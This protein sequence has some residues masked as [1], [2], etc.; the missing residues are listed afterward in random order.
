MG[1]SLLLLPATN[2]I[3]SNA[4]ATDNLSRTEGLHNPSYRKDDRRAIKM[5]RKTIRF[6]AKT[7]KYVAI[8]FFPTVTLFPR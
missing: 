5:L 6:D 2:E 8:D 4:T 7:G 3:V 1:V